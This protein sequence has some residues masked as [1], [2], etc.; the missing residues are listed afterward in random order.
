LILKH[1]EDHQKCIGSHHP[2]DHCFC[3]EQVCVE[4][5]NISAISWRLIWWWG[6][7]CTRATRIDMSLHWDTLSWFAVN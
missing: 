1:H 2:G 6:S 4:L 3:L 5:S 7:L